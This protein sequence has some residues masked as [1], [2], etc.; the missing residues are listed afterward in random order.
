MLA[1][2]KN[3]ATAFGG[4]GISPKPHLNIFGALATL[5]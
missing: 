5:P 2:K 3:A 1:R 4:I